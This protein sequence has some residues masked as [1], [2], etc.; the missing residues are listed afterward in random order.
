MGVLAKPTLALVLTSHEEEREMIGTLL[1]NS[2][3]EVREVGRVQP[4]LDL[5]A[6]VGLDVG[7]CFAGFADPDAAECAEFARYIA[8]D[9]PWVKVVI[10]APTIDTGWLPANAERISYPPLPLDIIIRAERIKFVRQIAV[11]GAE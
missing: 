2:G 8:R 6:S 7:M 10:S 4:A 9:Y 1:E 3:Y 5:L 11:L